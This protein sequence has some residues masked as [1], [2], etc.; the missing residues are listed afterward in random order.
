MILVPR[1]LVDK[2]TKEVE[3]ITVSDKTEG[4]EVYTFHDESTFKEWCKLVGL[5]LN[6]EPELDYIT[7]GNEPVVEIEIQTYH[8]NH[9]LRE[10]DFLDFME[11]PIDAVK[12]I[13]FSYGQLVECYVHIEKE[14]TTVY[15]PH[16]LYEK[17]FKQVDSYEDKDLENNATLV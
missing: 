4:E 7:K 14:V 15:R 1:Y 12:C 13:G 6:V 16:Y 8:T 17:V 10:E 5:E 2:N 9:V 3:V 11:L